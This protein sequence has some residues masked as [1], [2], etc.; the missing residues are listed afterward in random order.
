MTD[1]IFKLCMFITALTFTAFFAS[2]VMPPLIADPDIFAALTAGFVNPFA[3]G[4]ATDVILCWVVLTIWVFHEAKSLQV[5]HGWVC[6]V[7]GA[8]PGVAVGLPIYLI[9]RSTQIKQVRISRNGTQ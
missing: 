7:L 2:T 3:S 4:Y 6:V 9:L 1:Q 5:K 8:F